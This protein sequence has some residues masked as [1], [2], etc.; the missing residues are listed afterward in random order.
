ML[1][2]ERVSALVHDGEFSPL[3]AD[4]ATDLVRVVSWP[5][6]GGDPSPS[7]DGLIEGAAGRRPPGR[8]VGE[9]RFVLLTSGTTGQPRGASRPTPRQADPLVALL[10]RIPL[11]QRDTTLVASP[12]F[13]AWGFA[14]LGLGM[15]LSST[16]VLQRHFDPE[17]T[18]A[19]IEAQRVRVLAAVP[20]M[21]LRLL[22]LPAEV[23]SRYDLSSLEVV[24]SSGSSLPGDLAT[25]FM[26]AFGD[27][28][29]NL[30][31]ST[32]AAWAGIATPADLRAAPGTAGR[33]PFGTEVH[34]VDAAGTTR[35]PRGPGRILVHNSMMQQGPTRP[36]AAAA[37]APDCSPRATWATS[38]SS[39]GSS[40]TAATTT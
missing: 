29:Y 38:T 30:Y 2:R 35:P 9:T 12:L 13:H 17:A 24:A 37:R 8:A 28:L 6:P 18:L 1:E 3:L 33:P 4:A 15:V 19:A 7:I 40:S 26:D 20:V 16:L 25:R 32:E 36:A 27:V 22:D 23:R 39:G 5:E 10:S 31:G 11:R 34:I 14:H 21:L